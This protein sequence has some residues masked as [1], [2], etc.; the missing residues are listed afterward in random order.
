MQCREGE[1]DFKYMLESHRKYRVA[2]P[3]GVTQVH[4]PLGGTLSQ[5]G[6]A[7]TFGSISYDSILVQLL[8]SWRKCTTPNPTSP[9]LIFLSCSSPRWDNLPSGH[10]R[11]PLLGLF[12]KGT[13][14]RV[15]NTFLKNWN[16][17]I[18]AEE[19]G[20]C[21]DGFFF[22]RFIGKKKVP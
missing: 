5:E 4:Y 7:Q 12:G 1:V 20:E 8:S 14:I 6:P 2:F 18:H 16:I 3:R 13:C 15:K 10:Q 21:I 9:T 11:N 22:P 19:R 17:P